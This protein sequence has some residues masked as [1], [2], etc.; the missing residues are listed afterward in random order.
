MV[1]FAVV[2]FIH[3]CENLQYSPFFGV[4]LFKDAQSGKNLYRQYVKNETNSLFGA[5]HL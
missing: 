3:V 2:E 5:G 1:S 4:M